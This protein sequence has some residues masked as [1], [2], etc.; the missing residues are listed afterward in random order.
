MKF[1]DGRFAIDSMQSICLDEVG[2]ERMID[3]ATQETTLIH[4]IFG[5]HLQSQV[6]FTLS[7]HSYKSFKK[8]KSNC[9][10]KRSID[11]KNKSSF[12]SINHK[13]V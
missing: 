8:K 10:S 12:G 13:N 5:G 9:R 2:G 3:H 7:Y 4:H 6:I 1:E 11:V